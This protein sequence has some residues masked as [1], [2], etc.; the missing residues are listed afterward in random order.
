MPKRE[1]R[2]SIEMHAAPERIW[3]VL[4]NFEKFSEWNPFLTTI[5][6]A[7][8]EGDFIHVTF[9]NGFKIS[10]RVCKVEPNKEFRWAGKLGCGGLFD[11]EHYFVL[12]TLP[13]GNTQL[14]HGENFSGLLLPILPGL[15]HDTEIN[16][17]KM[18]EALKQRCEA[19][20]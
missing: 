18:N 8:K 7:A 12:S 13:N 2:T 11:G 1:I 15:L 3:D 20:S 5:T 17:K 9:S 6:G 4:M 19:S 16:F 14:E 10:P